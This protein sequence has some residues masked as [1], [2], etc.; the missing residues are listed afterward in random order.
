[1]SLR[2]RSALF[3]LWF[4]AG[5]FSIFA[6]TFTVVNSA[7]TGPGS[8][9]D[10]LNNLSFDSTNTITFD[11][12]GPGVHSI[13]VPTELYVPNYTTI[14]GYTQ[15]GA[16]ANTLTNGEDAVLLIELR[17]SSGLPNTG[18]EL[19]T[20][21]LVRGLV[22]DGF[23]STGISAVSG[24]VIQG[25]FL[26]TDPS[27]TIAEGN[28]YYGVMVTMYGAGGNVLVGGPAPADRNLISGNQFSGV[29]IT[30]S[31]GTSDIEGNFIGTD[32]TGTRPLGNAIGG[33]VSFATGAAMQVG[34]PKSGEGNVIAFNG[35]G[36][37][38]YPA[39]G[40]TVL[41]NSIF[42]NQ[43]L[44]I[45]VGGLGGGAGVLPAGPGG[46]SP[47]ITSVSVTGG[48]TKVQGT[49]QGEPNA[50]YR[51]EFFA[52]AGI[53]AIG[54]G[55]GQ[56]F[57]GFESV[58]TGA[59]GAATFSATFPGSNQFISATATDPSG[60][61]S[62]FSPNYSA[63]ANS[64]AAGDLFIALN[65][66]LVQWR[67]PDGTLV[68]VLNPGFG[69]DTTP[70][71]M[72]FDEDGDLY[73]TGQ[74]NS[75]V[76][77]FDPAG[78]PLG[79]Y[80]S[81]TNGSSSD[82]SFD[83]AGHAYVS[84]QEASTE[85]SEYD[86]NGK[87]LAGF[88]PDPQL[89]GVYR[90]QLGPDQ[91]TAYFD[92]FID[93]FVS[94]YYLPVIERFDLTTQEELPILYQTSTN[95][96]APSIYGFR[97]LADGGAVLSSEEGL[98]RVGINPVHPLT[99]ARVTQTYSAPGEGNWSPIALDADGSSFWAGTDTGS[100]IY[101][102][103]L[104]TGAILSRIDTGASGGVASIA[105]YGGPVASASG[106][107]LGMAQGASN[108]I[109]DE[110]I[111]NT[112]TLL[113]FH[114]NALTGV[115]VSDTLP[116]GATF[117]SASTT[118]GTFKVTGNTVAFE[119]G[120][121]PARTN[122]T[123]TIALAAA[124]VGVLTNSATAVATGPAP[125]SY[126]ASSVTTIQPTPGSLIV[127]TTSD[128]GPGSLRNAIAAA[129][130]AAGT[131]IITFNIPGTAPHVIQPLS[132]LPALTAP[133]TI[134]G[135]SQSGAVP[136]TSAAADNATLAIALDG[137]NAGPLADGLV[138]DGG[139][140]IVRGMAIYNWS[141]NGIVL[142]QGAGN[143]VSGNFIGTDATGAASNSPNAKNGILISDSLN[144]NIGGPLPAQRNLISANG[145]SGVGITGY[146]TGSNYIQGN[147]IGVN[148]SGAALGNALDGLLVSSSDNLIGGT[149]VGDANVIDFNGAAGVSVFGTTSYNQYS[150]SVEQ[151]TQG[152]GILGNSIFGNSQLGID[153]APAGVTFVSLQSTGP[154]GPVSFP[155]LAPITPGS[156]SVKGALDS[157]PSETFRIEIFGNS[158]TDPSGYG[159][160][161]T[162]L[163]AAT[164]TTDTN[165]SANFS[166]PL[167]SPLASGDFIT[168]TAIE[169]D[170]LDTSEFSLAVEVT[171][172]ADLAVSLTA[173]ADPAPARQNLTYTIT[174][175]NPG[176]GMATDVLLTNQ[177]PEYTTFISADSGGTES[178]ASPP[179]IGWSLGTMP[180]GA[181][182]N[183]H[184]I[185]TP[186]R[187][188][189]ITATASVSA[190]EANLTPG[191]ASTSLSVAVTGAPRLL[192][193]TNNTDSAAGS[194]RATIN[195]VNANGYGLDTIQFDIP[196]SGVQTITLQSGL[197]NINE[198]VVIDG[199][200]QPGAQ[201]NTLSNGDNAVILIQLQ[202]TN[203]SYGSIL[204]IGAGNSTVRGLV[205]NG[206]GD[207]GIYV[208][209]SYGSTLQTNIIIAGN[210]IG[211]SPAGT[212]A[213][214]N[215]LSAG[216]DVD[217]NSELSGVQIGSAN[218]ADRNVISGNGGSGQSS[219][220]SGISVNYAN[221]VVIQGD[222]IGVDA[223]G[224]M[225]L[226]NFGDG[227]LLYLSD[228][229]TLIGGTGA[230]DANVIAYNAT[231]GVQIGEGTNNAVLGNSIFNNG[232]LGIHLGFDYP[233][234]PGS[235]TPNHTGGP[236]AGP[237]NLQ[238]YPVLSS[239]STVD[240]NTTVQGTLNSAAN[241]T[242]LLQFFSN[243][244]P[245]ASFY[246]QGQT[247]LGEKSIVTDA[248]GNA[249]FDFTVQG[250]ASNVTATATDPD[251]NTSEFS[252]DFLA[253]SGAFQTGDLVVGSANGIIQW[254]RHDGTPVALLNVGVTNNIEALAFDPTGR[255]IAAAGNSLVVFDNLGNRLGLLATNVSV[256]SFAFN[257]AGNFY[258][259][260][261]G[262]SGGSG[263]GPIWEFDSSGI[264]LNTFTV[265]GDDGA[266]AY[267]DLAADQETLY[268][269]SSGTS[270]ERY[271]VSS[272]L[273]LSD[274]TTNLTAASI[275]FAYDLR[276]LPDGSV[277]VGGGGQ[278]VARFDAS[279]NLSQTY[280]VASASGDF[281]VLALD[282]DG[283]SFWVSTDFNPSFL[284][285]FDLA[286]GTNLV[287]LPTFL[288]GGDGS[289]AANGSFAIFG[290]PRAAAPALPV[291]S[292]SRDQ[293][294]VVVSWPAN[295]SGFTLQTA[296]SLGQ[297]W[298]NLVTS[299]N[300][301]TLPATNSQQFFRLTKP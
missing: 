149:N 182:T 189:T 168:A 84:A 48:S 222:Y 62:E 93:L 9:S 118:L 138:V 194:L 184:V 35:V 134:D 280:S 266:P 166:V 112:L 20:G 27:G 101:K 25:N 274:F 236:V 17:A 253:P 187:V 206:T 41:G 74:T 286:T 191:N 156:T 104:A 200:S 179:Q 122:V 283:A 50:A 234:D 141:G 91:S 117:G 111:T 197:P 244:Q 216:I 85:V 14:D 209:P 202:Q 8:L 150:T 162:F 79:V 98:E 249:G 293:K 136:N 193:V 292:I 77:R 114:T 121:V 128:S 133:V 140:S 296:Q 181:V 18:L 5:N 89:Y 297:R 29:D 213:A 284:Y 119:L 148:P 226:G 59:N 28:G 56:T 186:V 188:G 130:A 83:A 272:R 224:Q 250:G 113:N 12:P 143:T 144:N 275:Y 190:L 238:N 45:S 279:G 261:G 60:N 139:Q 90:F 232:G 31:A 204:W 208:S 255:L 164:I 94:I 211:T 205:I 120:T 210:F 219:A 196:G 24:A 47:T 64:F 78:Q 116:A 107:Y 53:G 147:F 239:V 251:G 231:I 276:I 243:S 228:N 223:S 298:T 260:G 151:L 100:F 36:V 3:A 26:G 183:V 30:G 115:T 2:F 237:N 259:A 80:L 273:Q 217:G 96:N 269:T 252:A 105:V 75:I 264:L 257:A 49:I 42:S 6:D 225:P 240:G 58:T 51:L 263:G 39:L 146:N 99:L 268:Y 66:G 73:V 34:G 44:G 95:E 254:R 230:G 46:F 199:Y 67:H 61:T 215:S 173:S 248:N 172:A 170:N 4:L 221:G 43:G 102:F 163:A 131:G 33:V 288:P 135:Y 124:D 13:L 175:T 126:S 70:G 185:V 7:S 233:S 195:D 55:Q 92:G 10:V 169:L 176:P 203:Y 177:V 282:P 88:D 22:I 68:G 171:P 108:A 157:Y 245:G 103:D 256:R 65:N 246:G 54:Y 165:G 214:T 301:V 160:G 52:N 19:G 271:N 180:P 227:I 16:H 241:T 229:S 247:F 159:Q 76:V 295:F 212:A 291:M 299:T 290:E 82:I 153:M 132:P 97:L 1:M 267:L 235:P 123:M 174:V 277:L 38:N 300:S 155:V 125:E 23:T 158:V 242:Y 198:P 145:G 201:P 278:S 32:I 270:V 265:A 220:S 110:S 11:V 154:D 21:C 40:G 72:A 142:A 15:P 289:S 57:L 129:N 218:P 69:W 287:Q 167:S 262:Y 281:D 87:L 152:V 137:A 81:N 192:L 106:M 63:P 86:S 178:Y 285:R 127:T 109:P 161:Q 207:Q 71:G 37:W 258:A 294:N